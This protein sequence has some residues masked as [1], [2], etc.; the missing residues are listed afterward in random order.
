MPEG[1]E[2]NL[3]IET[4]TLNC[5]EESCSEDP[6]CHDCPLT[7]AIEATL[8]VGNSLPNRLGD[9]NTDEVLDILDLVIMVDYILSVD[10]SEYNEALRLLDRLIDVNED[11]IVNIL[12]AV[13]IV[14]WILN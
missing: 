3:T 6:Y 2:I 8:I 10:Q 4:V 13:L 1:T 7:P 5:Y 12:D 14:E 9:A 11:T